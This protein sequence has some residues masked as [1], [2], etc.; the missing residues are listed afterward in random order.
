MLF[1]IYL[2]SKQ[3]IIQVKKDITYR[4]QHKIKKDNRTLKVPCVGRK[5]AKRVGASPHKGC[6]LPN[7][8]V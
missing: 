2:G 7:S 3:P 6:V 4:V 8:K 5:C 1:R